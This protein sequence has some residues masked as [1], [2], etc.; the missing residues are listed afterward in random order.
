V[1]D[2]QRTDAE[3]DEIARRFGLPIRGM[4]FFREQRDRWQKEREQARE[5]DP[6]ENTDT[7]GLTVSG[8]KLGVNTDGDGKLYVRLTGG[9]PF[10]VSWYKATGGG[11]GDLVAQSAATAAGATA[12]MVEQ[13]SSGLSGTYDVAAAAGNESDDKHTITLYPDWRVDGARTFDGTDTITGDDSKSLDAWYDVCV[14]MTSIMQ[15]ALDRL[16]T[17][18]NQF[19]ISD[20]GNPVAQLA[21]WFQSDA[22][23]LISHE[24]QN[25]SNAIS[26]LRRGLLDDERQAMVDESTGSTQTVIERVM[27][28]AAAVAGTNNDG[29]GTVASHTPEEHCPAGTY[30]L[31]CVNGLGNENGGEGEQFE[32]TFTPEAGDE[33][34]DKEVLPDRLTIKKSYQAPNGFGGLSGITLLRTRTKTGDGSDLNLSPVTDGNWTE[35]GEDETFTNGGV[36]YWQ[37][38]ASGGNW[39]VSFYSTAGRTSDSLVAQSPAT[40][41]ATTFQATARNNSGLSVDGKVGTAPVDTTQGTLDLNYHNTQNSAGRPDEYTIAVTETSSGD[42]QKTLADVLEFYLN[43]A[44][45]SSETLD[46]GLLARAN[47][48]EPYVVK[49]V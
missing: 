28:G 11:G 19:G 7:T 43:S 46:D 41:A 32:V 36:L 5:F 8:T 17:F 22:S 49:D 47:T 10:V 21:E 37:I 33:N 16:V 12:T 35:A 2:L 9:G 48:F 23:A 29:Q 13:N 24:S 14:D 40:A 42:A 34:V 26:Q 20:T 3:W 39:I 38:D 30:R 18:Y 25:S 6:N 15:Q 1:A 31:R 27:A 45:A 44:T 4:R